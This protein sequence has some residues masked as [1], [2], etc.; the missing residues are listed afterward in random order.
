M[1]THLV[2]PRV[3]LSASLSI[4]DAAYAEGSMTVKHQSELYLSIHGA[5]KGVGE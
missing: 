4:D 5:L 3:V 1:G 2:E